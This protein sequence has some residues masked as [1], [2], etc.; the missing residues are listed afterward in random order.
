VAGQ[1]RG[2]QQEEDDEAALVMI[3]ALPV[4]IKA[5]RTRMT[6]LIRAWHVRARATNHPHHKEVFDDGHT[7][8]A[9]RRSP[10]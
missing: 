9:A 7:T 3:S 10:G 6:G 1:W 8:A 4:A 2:D 5:S